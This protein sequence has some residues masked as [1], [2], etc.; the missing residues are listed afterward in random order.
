M[1]GSPS[2]GQAFGRASLLETVEQQ[3][4]ARKLRLTPI[5]RAMLALMLRHD[6]PTLR[7]VLV[8]ALVAET[9]KTAPRSA[10]RA[11]DFLTVNG[12]AHK[13][14]GIDAYIA[15]AH[16]HTHHAPQFASCAAC[17]RV[18]ELADEG[19]RDALAAAMRA[20][21][22]E[23]ASTTLQVESLCAACAADGAAITPPRAARGPGKAALDPLAEPP[24]P[25][26]PDAA[27]SPQ[28][29]LEDAA[30]AHHPIR[31]LRE[32][33]DRLLI[34]EVAGQAGR[35]AFL[36]AL[37]FQAVLGVPSDQALADRL[38][39]DA[40]AQWFIG[41]SGGAGAWPAAEIARMRRKALTAAETVAF[42]RAFFADRRVRRLLQRPE[43]APDAALIEGLTGAGA[44]LERADLGPETPTLKLVGDRR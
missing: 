20:A 5:R 27:A 42:F 18:R 14:V 29:R 41:R 30:L 38:S 11:L 34:A 4:A 13:V 28:S 19:L 22:F 21:G 15:C 32:T 16:P 8:A 9:P 37:L 24:P 10:E 35:D 43:F 39:F 2:F 1:D 12:F 23:D 44:G 31:A 3:C 33:A 40:L 17:G 6:K 36:R 7:S 25:P 26:T